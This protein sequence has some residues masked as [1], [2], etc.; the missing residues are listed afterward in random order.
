MQH[1]I[2]EA[3]FNDGE[4]QI[5]DKDQL[6]QMK[7]V[8]RFKKG[9]ECVLMDGKGKKANAVIEEL[10]R[11]GAILTVSE[12]KDCPAT[13]RNLRLF[14]ALSKK[15]STFELIVQKATE[16]GVTHIIPFTSERTQVSEIRKVSRLS[17]IIKEACEQS[18]RCYMP[19]LGDVSALDSIKV[20]GKVLVGDARVDAER[21]GGMDLDQSEDISVVIGPEGGLS[22][23]ELTALESAGA[24]VFKLGETVLRMETAAIA[25]LSVVAFG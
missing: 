20:S 21:L 19:E 6:H 11:K 16:L 4:I 22:D 10:H 23:E 3:G 2:L 18:E 14:I 17:N 25:A 12:V 13:G 5:E 1:F 24:T 8:L 15:P 9:D 7:E